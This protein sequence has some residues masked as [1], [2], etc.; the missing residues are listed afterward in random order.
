MG[1][2][3]RRTVELT[4]TPEKCQ[5]NEDSL[6]EELCWGRKFGGIPLEKTRDVPSLQKEKR[7]HQGSMCPPGQTITEMG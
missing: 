6:G 3:K 1:S 5:D 2:A 7:A 4:L